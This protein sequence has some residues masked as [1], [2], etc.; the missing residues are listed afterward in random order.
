[1]GR[2]NRSQAKEAWLLVLHRIK[3]ERFLSVT[4]TVELLYIFLIFLMALFLNAQGRAE[5]PVQILCLL[6]NRRVFRTFDVGCTDKKGLQFLSSAFQFTGHTV[7]KSQA[8][9]GV[10]KCFLFWPITAKYFSGF[11]P[12]QKQYLLFAI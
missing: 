10:W 1:M 9:I 12:W 6:M 11:A 4:E 7:K 3:A 8:V 2:A 5:F